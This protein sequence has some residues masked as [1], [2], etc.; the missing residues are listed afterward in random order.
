MEQKGLRVNGGKTKV[1]FTWYDGYP[2]N[3][4]GKFFLA[5]S[6]EKVGSNSAS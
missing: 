6:V 1:M 3:K 4:S 2:Q 5:V